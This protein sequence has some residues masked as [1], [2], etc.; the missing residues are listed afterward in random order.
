M[1]ISRNDLIVMAKTM[2]GEA[3]GEGYN[4]LVAV[5]W[6]IQNRCERGG[7]FGNTIREVCLKPYQFSCWNNDDCNKAKIDRLTP[8]NS[9]ELHDILDIAKGNL[10]IVSFSHMG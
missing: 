1:G 9:Q 4:G 7:W 2:W 5:G 6:V 8:E 3:R 10:S